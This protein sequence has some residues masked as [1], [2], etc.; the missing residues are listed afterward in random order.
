MRLTRALFPKYTNSSYNLTTTT[1][2]PIQKWTQIVWELYSPGQWG[3]ERKGGVDKENCK[4]TRCDGTTPVTTSWQAEK[5]EAGNLAGMF[6][7]HMGLLQNDC[8]RELAFCGSPWKTERRHT[9]CCP[10]WMPKENT[11][12][13]LHL[14]L[15]LMNMGILGFGWK[16]ISV[17]WLLWQGWRWI[18]QF[19][20]NLPMGAVA[21]L[22]HG[23]C[24]QRP[25]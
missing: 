12:A 9:W 15:C 14:L 23:S 21:N 5:G 1:N 18:L 16:L 6:V 20:S 11:F 22:T 19:H 10:W 2:N 3:G 13:T 8:E 24:S 17:L 4:T 25:H 7:Q